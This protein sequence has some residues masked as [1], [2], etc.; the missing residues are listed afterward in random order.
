MPAVADFVEAMK[1]KAERRERK[2]L[3]YNSQLYRGG[4]LLHLQSSL[5]YIKTS[6]WPPLLICRYN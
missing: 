6:L 5:A 1:T 2:K 4:G 3:P